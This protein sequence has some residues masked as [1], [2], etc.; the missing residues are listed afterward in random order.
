M[1]NTD[2]KKYLSV[3]R[4]EKYKDTNEIT[5]IKYHFLNTK[6]CETFYCSLSYLEIVLRNK[7]DFVFS[8]YFGEDWIFDS[9]YLIGHNI[10]TMKRARETL[11]QNGQN[12]D[13]K[14]NLIA[15]LPFGFWT[16]LF[17]SEYK[18]KIWNT[19]K[20]ILKDIFEYQKETLIL[21]KTSSELNLI[22]EYRN[23]IFHYGSI[24]E[25][26][27][28]NSKH[29]DFIDINNL[30]KRYLKLISG[31]TISNKLKKIDRFNDVFNETKNT[32][33]IKK[34]IIKHQEKMLLKKA[35][36]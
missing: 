22:R 8:K 20:N 26:S 13:D 12:Q 10:E 6:L 18:D 14:N 32:D 23:K 27:L 21:T 16:L 36:K 24:L 15:E 30:I 34:I 9:Q 31:N 25:N 17:K 4:L 7:I 11:S 19:N 29:I 2:V 33:L 1:D 35:K 5:A 3:K 28:N